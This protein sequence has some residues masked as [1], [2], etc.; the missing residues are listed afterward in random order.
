MA[1]EKACFEAALIGGLVSGFGRHSPTLWPLCRQTPKVQ[2]N[3]AG[4]C[5]GLL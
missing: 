5:H 1:G 2:S 4:H 3:T